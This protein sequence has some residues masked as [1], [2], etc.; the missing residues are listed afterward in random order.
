MMNTF[1]GAS[2]GGLCSVFVKHRLAGTYAPSTRYDVMTLCNG[3]LIGCVSITAACNNIEPWAAI[4]IGAGSSLVYGLS[5]RLT[6]WM[7]IDDPLEAG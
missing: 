5:T 4:L 2:A 6:R 3:I 1:L 7:K